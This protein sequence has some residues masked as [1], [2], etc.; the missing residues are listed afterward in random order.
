MCRRLRGHKLSFKIIA[1][2]ETRLRTGVLRRRGPKCSRADVAGASLHCFSC[3]FAQFPLTT[4]SVSCLLLPLPCLACP[5]YQQSQSHSTLR[6]EGPDFGCVGIKSRVPFS[7]SSPPSCRRRSR[8]QFDIKDPPS[9]TSPFPPPV[10]PKSV[11][12]IEESGERRL[13]Y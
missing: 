4:D 1:K 5:I 7:F 10:Q 11:A 13:S 6:A 9:Q 2:H 8:N 3:P 12:R